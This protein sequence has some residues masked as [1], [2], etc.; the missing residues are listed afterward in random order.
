M[1]VSSTLA[2]IEIAGV[3]GAAIPDRLDWHLLGQ[4]YRPA[5]WH[6]GAA[7]V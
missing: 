4:A 1:N 7:V 2:I 6:F 5:A 3:G